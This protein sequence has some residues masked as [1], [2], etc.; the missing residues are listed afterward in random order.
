MSNKKLA[1]Q[2]SQIVCVSMATHLF[3]QLYTQPTMFHVLS[4]E[5][6]IKLVV[7]WKEEVINQIITY[8]NEISVSNRGFK[9]KAK[10]IIKHFNGGIR[11]SHSEKAG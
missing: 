3:T 6:K 1:P 7:Y 4:Q 10:I 5:I 2:N 9:G 8:Q 11:P